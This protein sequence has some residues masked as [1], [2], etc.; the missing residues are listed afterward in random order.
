MRWLCFVL[1]RFWRCVLGLCAAP[2]STRGARNFQVPHSCRSAWGGAPVLAAVRQCVYCFLS[3]TC[4][5]LSPQVCN[6][7]AL[8]ST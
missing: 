6:E 5:T 2:P 1:A 8:L 7:G 4:G 3:H